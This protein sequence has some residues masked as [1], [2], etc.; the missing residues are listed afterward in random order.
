VYHEKI[1][2]SKV[3]IR[4]S[5]SISPYALAFF[6]GGRLTCD[7][8]QGILNLDD[9]WIRFSVKLKDASVIEAV[10]TAFDE[11]LQMK[12]ENP[13][14]DVSKTNLVK[15]IVRLVTKQG[16]VFGGKGGASVGAA[17]GSGFNGR[18]R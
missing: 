17:S 7:K 3:Y 15:E 8:K 4:D 16:A 11:L 9:G 10:R 14:L 13:E 2:T 5:S 1:K 12:I 18:R 6:G